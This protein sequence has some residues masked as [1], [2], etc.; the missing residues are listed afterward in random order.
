MDTLEDQ[1]AFADKHSLRFPLIADADGEI[2]RAYGAIREGWA[3]AG[4]KTVVVGQDGKVLK[5]YPDAQAAGHA[6]Q[7]LNDLRTRLA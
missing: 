1:K 2:C 6:E 3:L 7:V 5:T 4:R